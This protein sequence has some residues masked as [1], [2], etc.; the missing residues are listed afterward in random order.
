MEQQRTT[1]HRVRNHLQAVIMGA[2]VL[3]EQLAKL[4]AAPD[5]VIGAVLPQIDLEA[6]DG[7]AEKIGSELAKWY[8]A[9]GASMAA[10]GLHEKPA[11]T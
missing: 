7:A 8:K 4:E 3:K 1:I 11:N 6:L 10:R 9:I 2:S 5:S